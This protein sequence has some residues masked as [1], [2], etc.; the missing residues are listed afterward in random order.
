MPLPVPLLPSRGIFRF[1]SRMVG[2]FT[3]PRREWAIAKRPISVTISELYSYPKFAVVQGSK[4]RRPAAATGLGEPTTGLPFSFQ[5][6]CAQTVIVAPLTCVALTQ[7]LHPRSSRSL[8][9][10]FAKMEGQ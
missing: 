2:E 8:T 7:M 9:P 5:A 10:A 1:A 3:E 6:V 4:P